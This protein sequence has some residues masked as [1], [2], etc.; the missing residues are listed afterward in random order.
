MRYEAEKAPLVVLAGRKNGTGSSRDWEAKGT[1]QADHGGGRAQ[2]IHHQLVG[3]GLHASL[4][5]NS[6]QTSAWR[7]TRPSPSSGLA[8]A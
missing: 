3:M 1:G 5:E 4:K 2:S 6:W 7:A 8:R